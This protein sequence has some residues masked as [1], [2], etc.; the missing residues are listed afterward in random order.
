M[1][2]A[3]ITSTSAPA[4][5][6]AAPARK[7]FFPNLDGLRFLAFFAVFLFHSFY[8][9]DP[10]IRASIWYRIPQEL[11]R[12]GDL[13]VNFFFVLSGFLITYLLLDEQRLNGRIAIGMF[14]MRRVLRIWP[15]YFVVVFIGFIVFPIVKAQFGYN[16]LHETARP[17]YFLTF[18][19]NF[20]HLYYGCQTPTLTVLWSVAVEEQF[21]LVWPLL[22]AAVPMRRQGWLFVGVIAGSLLFRALHQD[23]ITMLNLHTF[24]LVG[25]MALGG[26]V[27]WLCFRDNRL[28]DAVAAMPRWGVVAGYVA[29]IAL[30]AGRTGL[31]SVPGYL[32][33]DRL[34]LAIFFAFVLLEQNY[35]QRSLVKMSQ[36]KRLSYWGNYT[37]GLY[38]LHFLA[39]LMAYQLLHRLHLNTTV[40]GTVVGDNVV[41]LAIA[42]AMS[43][44]SFT[45]Y[46]KPFLKLKNRFSF[47]KTH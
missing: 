43:W 6:A 42:M 15:L 36:F 40:F 34:L 38:C 32:V 17:W 3:N 5:T 21:Y 26:L 8:T 24:S 41:G 2:T 29:G 27:A 11:T 12:H 14:Y 18:L 10:A 47:I 28:T 44:V 39:L 45:F 30:L 35:A 22:V 7:V 46:E 1:V 9:A 33:I 4:A 13:G 16:V 37:Y 25:D 23:N 19:T 20:N 31:F